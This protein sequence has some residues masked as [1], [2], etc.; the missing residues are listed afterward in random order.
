M[1]GVCIEYSGEMN[2]TGMLMLASVPVIF[3]LHFAMRRSALRSLVSLDELVERGIDIRMPHDLLGATRQ[4]GFELSPRWPHVPEAPCSLWV[5][6]DYVAVASEVGRPPFAIRRPDL[7]QITWHTPANRWPR[8][9]IVRF[10]VRGGAFLDRTFYA[11]G[12]IDLIVRTLLDADFP[13][14]SWG[15]LRVQR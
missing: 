5:H 7:Q 2:T 12:P 3:A 10:Q 4:G 9:S 8:T 13:L 14:E 15:L 6:P 1:N 11:K